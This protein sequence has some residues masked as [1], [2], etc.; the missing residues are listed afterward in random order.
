MILQVIA[1]DEPSGV[2]AAIHYGWDSLEF[3]TRWMHGNSDA[4]AGT[5]MKRNRNSKAPEGG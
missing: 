1:K 4:A 5:T 2:L 3:S